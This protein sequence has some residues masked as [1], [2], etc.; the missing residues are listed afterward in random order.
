RGVEGTMKQGKGPVYRQ[1][2]S[3]LA[4]LN[5][6]YK[7]KQERTKDAQKRLAGV[8]VRLAQI[9]RELSTLDGDLAKLTGEAQ[10][11]EQRIKAAETVSANEDSAKLD[12]A[13]VLPQF[14][15]ARAAFRQQPNTEQLAALQQQCMQLLSAMSSAQ[16]TKERARA[17]DCDPKQAAEASAR[18]FALNAGMNAFRDN[19][20]GGDKLAKQATTD[21]LLALGRKCLNASC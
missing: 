3:E 13:R 12:P 16:A 10:T 1:R 8:E 7:I 19:C 9:D 20:A 6:Q 15:R 17:I 5:D 21:P 4:T 18:V 11:A 2:M 14:E